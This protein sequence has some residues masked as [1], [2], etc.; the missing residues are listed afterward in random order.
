MARQ[1]EIEGSRKVIGESI[2]NQI[3][4]RHLPR[5][6][7]CVLAGQPKP[8]APSQRRAS[9]RMLDVQAPEPRRLPPKRGRP[10]GKR[11]SQ[12]AQLVKRPVGRSPSPEPIVLQPSSNGRVRA[13]PLKLREAALEVDIDEAAE[14]QKRRYRSPPAIVTSTKRKPGRPSARRGRWATALRS[15]RGWVH[16]VVEVWWLVG[17]SRTTRSHPR[18]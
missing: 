16:G 13:A 11:P 1:E 2:P 7:V 6:W 4:G 8:W 17:G 14:T 3:T 15:R 12:L 18:G 10:A 5:A 9:P